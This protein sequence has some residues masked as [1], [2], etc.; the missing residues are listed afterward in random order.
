MLLSEFDI[1]YTTQKAIKRQA[2][3][4]HLAEHAA[5]DYEPIDWDFPDEDILALEA[6]SDSDNWKLLFDGAVNQLGCGLGAVLVSPKGDHFP[7]AIELDFACT[8]NIAEYEACIAGIHAALDMNVRDLEIY[9][10]SALI[11]CQTNGDWQTK[12]PKLIP[13][14]QYL[15][16]LIKK[17]RFISLN[18]MP[19]AKNQ[20]ADALATLASMIQ[21]SGDDVIKPLVIEISQEP[22]HCMEIKVDD[23]PWFHDIKQFLQNGEYP[24]H[25]SEANKKTIRKLAASYF[26]SGNTL[27]KCSAD[28]TLLRCD[29]ETE[30]KQ[31]M[32]EVH[33]GICGTHANGRMLARKILR[34]GYYWLTT[35]HDCI[36]YARA[37]HK[38]QIYADHINAPPSLLHNMSAPWPFSMW[39]IDV[40]GTINP[41]ASNGHQFILVAIDYFT[42]WV[43]AASYASVTKKVVTRF[44][45]REIICRYGQPEAIITDNASNL[46]NDMMTALCKQFKIKYLNSSPYRPKMNGAVEAANK[47]IKKILAKMAV[48]YKDWHE[49]LPYALH[50]YRTSIHTSTGATPYSLVYGMEAVLPV[51]LEIPSMRILS[52]SGIDEE[53]LIQKRIDYLNLLDEKRLAALC[54]GQCYQRRMAAAY[55]KKVKPRIFHQG[56]LILRKIMPNERDPKGK[57]AP[58]Y[59]GPYVVK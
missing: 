7:V 49:M 25:A 28:M 56:D 50:A 57:F 13:Y 26:L 17:F 2:I 22:A 5:E 19:R 48:T 47:N 39:G 4:D 33:E 52:E 38:C 36:K 46:N 27:Y 51:E 20:F 9:G 40:I 53:D 30:A 45:K 16:T 21:I 23:K 8:N 44:I 18:H 59:E 14:H 10:D 1:V 42:K 24:L 54:H 31:V 41:K 43:E 32:T 29:D 58:N 11:I 55:N 37:C 12:D 6:K 15:E 35:E 3:T 34:A